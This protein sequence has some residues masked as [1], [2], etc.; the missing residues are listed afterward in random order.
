M[1]K[2]MSM[3]GERR[4]VKRDWFPLV[5]VKADLLQARGGFRR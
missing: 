1:K 4:E 5:N 2:M 3:K